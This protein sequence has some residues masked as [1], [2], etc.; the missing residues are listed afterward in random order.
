MNLTRR[1]VGADV[2][3]TDKTA[4]QAYETYQQPA[5]RLSINGVELADIRLAINWWYSS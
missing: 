2:E 3:K 4:E 5:F 1:S